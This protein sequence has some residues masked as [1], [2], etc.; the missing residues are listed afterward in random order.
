MEFYASNVNDNAFYELKLKKPIRLNKIQIYELVI[1][2]SNCTSLAFYGNQNSNN[3][4]LIKPSGKE[5][6]NLA[7]RV[8]GGDLNCFWISLYGIY[9]L[10][11]LGIIYRAYYLKQKG[12]IL[13][14]DAILNAMVVGTIYFTLM[15]IFSVPGTPTFDSVKHKKCLKK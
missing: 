13:T 12:R 11:I 7:F 6:I 1:S 14:N 2:S 9:T 8:Y 15:Y 3:S 5:N 10:V 4:R